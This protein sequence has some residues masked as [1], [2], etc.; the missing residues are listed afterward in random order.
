MYNTR[1]NAIYQL[2]N[3]THSVILMM[4]LIHQAVHLVDLETNLTCNPLKA[5]PVLCALAPTN[6]LLSDEPWF[7]AEFIQTGEDRHVPA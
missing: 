6:L 3:P 4:F 1:V 7:P 2:V 5:L